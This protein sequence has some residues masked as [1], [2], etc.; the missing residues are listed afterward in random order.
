M[1]INDLLT[2]MH[3]QVYSIYIHM[4]SYIVGFYHVNSIMCGRYIHINLLRVYKSNQGP[5]AITGICSEWLP[6]L[7]P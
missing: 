7:N 5:M 6:T 1:A 3:I 4:Y 2:G